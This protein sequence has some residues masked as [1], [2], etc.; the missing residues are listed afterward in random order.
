MSKK[1]HQKNLFIIFLT[2]C[3]LIGLGDCRFFHS[4][5]LLKTHLQT[6]TLLHL[7]Q[8]IINAQ[9]PEVTKKFVT[10][11][12]KNL[13]DEVAACICCMQE[14]QSQMFLVQL[15]YLLIWLNCD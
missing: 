4:E 2:L 6:P 3:A 10:Q 12:L 11:V 14:E 13:L 9:L 7:K 15:V 5:D 8:E 1:N